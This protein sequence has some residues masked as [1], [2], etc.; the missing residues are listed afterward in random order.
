MVEGARLI[1]DAYDLM[2]K[3]AGDMGERR[4][5]DERI[6][7]DEFIMKELG[8]KLLTNSKETIFKYP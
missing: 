8:V 5:F 4:F 3:S 1:G 6:P 7:P 2:F